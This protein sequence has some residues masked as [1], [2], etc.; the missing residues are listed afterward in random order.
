MDNFF[1]FFVQLSI[2][3]DLRDFLGRQF[4]RAQTELKKVQPFSWQTALML[5]LLSWLVFLLLQEPLAQKFVSFFGWIFLILGVDWALLGRSFKIPILG[6]PIRYGPWVT[7]AIVTLALYS[8]RIFLQDVPSALI[9]YPLI[10]AVI[11]SLPKF[12][13]PGP[14]FRT[15]DPAGRQDIVILLLL[16]SLYSCWFQ[17]H[18]ILQDIVEQYPSLLADDFSRSGFVVRFDQDDE[19][20]NGVPILNV[21]EATIRTELDKL[22]SWIEIQQWLRNIQS[23]VPQIATIVRYEVFGRQPQIKEYQL[24]RLNAQTLDNPQDPASLLLQLQ[25]LWYGSSSLGSGYILQRTCT[26]QQAILQIPN[27]ISPIKGPNYQ[28]QCGPIE[29]PLPRVVGRSEEDNQ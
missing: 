4:K 17:L 8:N 21:T 14:V 25:A 7:G 28:M 20:S 5:S 12:L 26:I 16:G 6:L 10:S 1:K 3:Q 13:R 2:F 22:N 23:Q 27:A 9:S 29:S 11:A 19:I 15:P 24:W 18:F